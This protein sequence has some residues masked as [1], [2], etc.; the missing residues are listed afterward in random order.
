METLKKL[1]YLKMRWGLRAMRL[2]ASICFTLAILSMQNPQDPPTRESQLKA[3]F[4]YNFT[5]F[6]AWPEKSFASKESPFVI[7]IL[8]KD[9]IG[10]YL[11]ETVK[12]ETVN[13]HPIEIRGYT[14][15]TPELSQCHMLFVDKSFD[16]KN[17]A[18]EITKD[19][20]ILT[21]SDDVDFMK[22]SGMLRFFLENGKVRFEVNT[23]LT[24][25]S[26]L[27]I[28]SKLLRLA[29]IYEKQE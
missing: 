28:S 23:D 5:Q 13:G 20:A 3:V 4:L 8:G 16:D 11:N 26:E 12:N 22:L 24:E 7:G 14:D 10:K 27:E 21:V 9:V 17:K 19:K 25:R 18:L 1:I 6:I 15:T 2:G 29:K